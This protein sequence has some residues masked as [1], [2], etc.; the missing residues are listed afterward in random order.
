MWRGQRGSMGS[1]GE[2]GWE[3][4]R[5]GIEKKEY[6]IW[7]ETRV[8]ETALVPETREGGYPHCRYRR[9]S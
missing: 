3:E 6:V 5:R 4:L 2:S 1:T 7:A 8:P 9:G